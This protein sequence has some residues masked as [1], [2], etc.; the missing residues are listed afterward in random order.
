MQRWADLWWRVFPT[1]AAR[2][3]VTAALCLADGAYLTA[4]PLAAALAPPV[5]CSV[6]LLLGWAHTGYVEPNATVFIA[7]LVTFVVL[8]L[9]GSHGAALGAY[10]WA[11]YVLGDLFLYALAAPEVASRAPSPWARLVEIAGTRALADGVLALLVVVIPFA[12]RNVA[13]VTLARRRSAPSTPS[14][15]IL[16]PAAS[17]FV[18]VYLWISAAAL[19]LQ[20]TFTWQ[21]Y[22]PMTHGLVQR[23]RDVSLTVALVG[24]YAAAVRGA[25]ESI[26]DRS[27]SY[28]ATRAR[29]R[30]AVRG[31]FVRRP[32]AVDFGLSLAG[33]LVLTFLMG[34]VLASWT[35]AAALFAGFAVVLA[36]RDLLAHVVPGWVRRVRRVPLALRVA[37]GL[38]AMYVAATIVLQFNGGADNTFL[39]AKIAAV[40]ATAIFALMIPGHAAIAPARANGGGA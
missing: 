26:A 8:L 19:L 23:L 4:W 24:G 15:Q 27:A 21:N 17:E 2:V 14:L 34:S 32:L 3:S 28:A 37:A 7:S 18:L 5:A 9:V 33:G 10:A 31:R 11:G 16:L 12:T 1:R 38:S 20:A 29:F 36:L 40:V 30:A 35:E 39:P 25:L 22:G 6:G 13:Y